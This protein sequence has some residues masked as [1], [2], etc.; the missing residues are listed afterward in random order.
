MVK[1]LDVF[2]KHFE[3]Y[4]DKYVLIGGTACSLAMEDAGLDFRAT[5]D[6]DIVLLVEAL[7]AE[8]L[9]AF[10]TFVKAG[11]YEIQQKSSGDKQFYKFLKPKNDKYPAQLELF[12]RNPDIL[13]IPKDSRFTPIPVEEDLSSLSA[14][15][16]DDGYY[17]LIKSG[18]VDIGG[19]S[20]VKPEYII[21]LKIRAWMDLKQRKEDGERID[22]SKVKKHRNDVFR[23][24]QII[25]PTTIIPV[26]IQVRD[27][28]KQGLKILETEENIDQTS[29]QL[30]GRKTKEVIQILKE[31]YRIDN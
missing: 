26:A 8:F 19:L 3:D 1:G 13:G 18:T 4:K 24:V 6:L 27:D 16:L 25:E 23:L 28:I 30:A 20:V 17:I 12:S 2:K 7:N 21:P 31:V 10:W 9:K 14:I 11:E 15:L 22:S 5:K 29:S